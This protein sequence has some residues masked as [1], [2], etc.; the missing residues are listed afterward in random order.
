MNLD[1]ENLKDG[2]RQIAL[3]LG[4]RE[5]LAVG[6]F[7]S[8]TRGNF[9]E[10]S[11]IDIF[12]ITREEFPLKEQDELYYTFSQLIPRFGR[13]ITVLVYD[14]NGLKRIPTWQTL[15]LVK[16][17]Y[18]VYDRAGIAKIFEKILQEAEKEG[19]LYDKEEEVFRLKRSGRLVFSLKE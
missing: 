13:D 18:F 2:I 19:I 4:K 11:D 3:G 5:I 15:N 9:D 7:G 8:L 1:I 10:R 17:A 6:L 12:V 14:I 16:D